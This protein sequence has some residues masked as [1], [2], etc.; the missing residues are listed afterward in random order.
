MPGTALGH[1]RPQWGCIRAANRLQ[2]AAQ[3]KIFGTHERILTRKG[4]EVDNG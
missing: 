4:S 2:S 1:V 3:A